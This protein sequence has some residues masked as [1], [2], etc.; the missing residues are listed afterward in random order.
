MV[1]Q[2]WCSRHKIGKKSTAL[3]S[4]Q[5][6]ERKTPLDHGKRKYLPINEFPNLS[7]FADPESLEQRN[8]QVPLRKDLDEMPENVSISFSPV[9]LL[10]NVW[11]FTE[12]TV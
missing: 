5:T 3:L 7:Q 4:D 9:L 12:V 2:S 10:R 6:N 8:D 11:P 1:N